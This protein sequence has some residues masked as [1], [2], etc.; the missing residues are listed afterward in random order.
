MVH[1]HLHR[2][3]AEEEGGADFTAGLPGRDQAQ[4]LLF[5]AREA[6]V[7]DLSSGAPAQTPLHGL[8]AGSKVA[9]D[10]RSQGA[11]AELLCP[12][13]RRHQTFDAGVAISRSQEGEAGP[14]RALGAL[15][16]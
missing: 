7:A 5:P 13:V 11:C 14:P 15:E 10:P 2:A 9:G 6:T 12:A 1:V 8:T 3:R 16:G 4:H